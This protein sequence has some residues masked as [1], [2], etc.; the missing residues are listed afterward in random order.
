[1]RHRGGWGFSPLY[2]YLQR[3]PYHCDWRSHEDGFQEINEAV[4]VNLF[5]PKSLEPPTASLLLLFFFCSSSVLDLYI[6]PNFDKDL[7]VTLRVFK[8]SSEKGKAEDRA[9]K[10]NSGPNNDKTSKCGESTELKKRCLLCIKAYCASVRA[11]IFGA[12][13]NVHSSFARD[14]KAIESFDRMPEFDSR[15]N[16]FTYNTVLHLLFEEKMSLLALAVYNRM[17]KSDCRPG[18]STFHLLI[19]GLCKSGRMED[20]V[21]LFDE[22]FERGFTPNSVTYTIVVSGL[23]RAEKIDEARS[24]IETMRSN[25]CEPDSVTRNALLNGYCRLGRLDEAFKLARSFKQEGFQLGLFDYS[26]LIDGL[27]ERG[28]FHEAVWLYGTVLEEGLVP[29]LVLYSVLINWFAKAGRME[30]AFGLFNEM[31]RQ[32]LVPDKFCYNALIEGL[33]Q[34]GSLNRAYKL[35]RELPDR[36]VVPDVRPYNIVINGLCKAQLIDKALKLF[37][38]IQIKGLSPSAVTYA[39]L[40]D[41]LCKAGMSVDAEI[42][43]RKLERN[44]PS[45]SNE[46][47]GREMKGNSP[48]LSVDKR[49]KLLCD[50]GEFIKAYELLRDLDKGRGVAPNISLYNILIAGL[51]W[52]RKFSEALKLFHQLQIRGLSP[53]AVTYGTLIDGLQDVGRFEDALGV[54]EQM[55]RNAC[56]PNLNLYIIITK[57]LCRIHRVLQAIALWLD[58]ISQRSGLSDWEDETIASLRRDYEMGSIKDVVM[59]LLDLD[60]ERGNGDC[61]PYIIWLIG[62][63]QVGRNEEALMIFDVLTMRGI[64]VTPAGC[65]WLVKNLCQEGKL[66]SAMR[67]MLFA[68]KKCFVLVESVGNLLINRLCQRNRRQEALYL[69]QKMS[70]SGYDMDKYLS[71]FNKDHLCSDGAYHS[72]EYKGG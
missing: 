36:G 31:V 42:L 27:F 37:E 7:H 26:C 63:C 40:I 67:V 51:C 12:L 24:L 21:A 43:Y 34:V 29:N 52:E 22:M 25:G 62:F 50:L 10:P 49:V 71:E 32:G 72:L 53:D 46:R 19:D 61:L 6:C 58:Y 54:F 15:P 55:V 65:V 20:A 48:P 64:D 41:G 2:N 17:I 60:H 38:E 14:C 56:A 35:L 13:W 44:N 47:I 18:R 33:C 3:A 59:G 16:V 30:E 68:L 70:I 39:T 45:P 23:C 1:M 9:E 8:Y 69:V 5:K 66:D 28:C 4:L 11:V 57:T